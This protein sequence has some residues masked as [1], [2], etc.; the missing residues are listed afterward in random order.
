[1]A[2]YAEIYIGDELTKLHAGL[3]VLERV[4]NL[5]LWL[6][7]IVT[8]P[9]FLDVAKEAIIKDAAKFM[10]ENGG[11]KL[12]EG[13][14]QLTEIAVAMP[15]SPS[16]IDALHGRGYPLNEMEFAQCLKASM[17]SA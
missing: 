3:E 7:G 16:S 2:G 5:E 15:L 13:D 1:M 9:V 12:E 17:T 6:Y 10:N 11:A 8:E 14:I 4:V